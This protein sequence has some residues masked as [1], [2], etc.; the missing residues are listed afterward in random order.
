M[1]VRDVPNQQGG[2][3]DMGSMVFS[4]SFL[5]SSINIQ[6]RGKKCWLDYVLMR[7]DRWLIPQR[8]IW[9]PGRG[10]QMRRWPLTDGKTSSERSSKNGPYPVPRILFVIHCAPSCWWDLF[11]ETLFALLQMAVWPQTAATPSWPR[12]SLATPAGWCVFRWKA[13]LYF[14]FD[15][16]Y[17]NSLFVEEINVSLSKKSVL[18]KSHCIFFNRWNLMSSSRSWLNTWPR[19]VQKHCVFSAGHETMHTSL[20]GQLFSPTE[21]GEHMS[22]NGSDCSRQRLR[23][24][25][26]PPVCTGR[27]WDPQG[28]PP[29]SDISTV[30]SYSVVALLFC[31]VS[32]IWTIH[33]C[34][35]YIL[36]WKHIF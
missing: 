31:P 10:R 15:M 36:I 1:M 2:G 7:M 33:T 35:F 32:I 5:D 11:L 26:Q 30:F 19:C 23:D 12:R 24:F 20:T 21:R 6:Q 28:A 8:E 16:F 29:L 13:V 34:I 27:R 22:G 9:F 3:G 25:S 4:E 17:I 18:E 14:L